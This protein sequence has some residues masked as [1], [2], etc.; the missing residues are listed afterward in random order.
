MGL[1]EKL[2]QDMTCAMKTG[3]KEVL[4]TIR[5]L[6]SQLK[7]ASIAKGASLEEEDVL[8]VLSKEAGKRREAVALYEQGGREDLARKESRELDTILQ[9]LPRP[10]N[11]DELKELVAE[12]VAETGAEGPKDMGKVMKTVMPR[13][14]GRAEGKA[15]QEMVKQLLG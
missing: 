14:Q 13:V 12:V 3:N 6:R 5:M 1:E 8:R 2:K 11:V 4:E 15:V 7:N 10:L 9:Y